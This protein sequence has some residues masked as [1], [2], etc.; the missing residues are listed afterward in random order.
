M[1]QE[2][3]DISR[4]TLLA[5]LGIVP[6]IARSS[7]SIA[8]KLETLRYFGTGTL[9]VGKQNWRVVQERLGI[10][11][12]FK[13]NGNDIGPVLAQMI[14]GTA[15]TDYDLG[16]VQGGAEIQMAKAG[17]ILPWDISKIPNFSSLWEWT[18][19]IP[20]LQ[21]N[22][23]QIAIPIVVNADSMIYLEKETGPIDSYA[24]IFDPKLKGRTS[25]EDA[26]INSVVFAA[27]FMK[28]NNIQGMSKIVNPGDLEED[29]LMTVMEFLKKHKKEG[30]FLKFWRGWEEGVSL[31]SSRRVV[32]MTGWE[33][34]VLTAVARGCVDARYAVPK[35]GY[36][37]WS[38]NLVMHRGASKHG[39][40]DAAHNFANWQLSG[41]YGCMLGS[42]RGYM[43]PNDR[44]VD[45]TGQHSFSYVDIDTG[46][47]KQVTK[48]QAEALDKHVKDKF[49][50]ERGQVYW[51]NTRPRNY[52]I[53]EK[54]WA[55][56]RAL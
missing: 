2:I 10:K 34:I 12:D 53:Y 38:N 18:K 43:V 36:E 11:V 50:I 40:I 48:E 29:E 54:Q 5:G 45:L 6:I 7:P 51:Q 44:C 23:A 13:D 3:S 35:E 14:S 4:R 22:G 9:D 19:K 47:T 39:V 15:A 55:E 41:E 24:A 20:T 33:P 32:V 56:L 26:W 49:L 42:L 21:Y 16:G 27:I 46:Q 25:M 31:I 30:Q 52:Q 17:T 28:E 1:Q 8:Q 37:G